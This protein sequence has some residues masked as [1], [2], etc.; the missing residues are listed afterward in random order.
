M[1]AYPEPPSMSFGPSLGPIHS[2]SSVS[3]S[4]PPYYTRINIDLE[5]FIIPTSL[6]IDGA[7]PNT[8][9]VWV[10]AFLGGKFKE[11]NLNGKRPFSTNPNLI[12]RY[13][14]VISQTDNYDNLHIFTF[15]ENLI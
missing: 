6:I 8:L 1:A 15:K 13:K 11:L 10:N 7:T 3:L 5:P 9:I 14:S 2:Q 12:H 4:A